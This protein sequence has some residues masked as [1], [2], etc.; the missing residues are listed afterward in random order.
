M[1]KKKGTNRSN[2]GQAAKTG[3]L[4]K[5][6][7]TYIVANAGKIPLADIARN[8]GRRLVSVEKVARAHA[9]QPKAANRS[10]NTVSG[11][12]NDFGSAQHAR[13]IS[14]GL[15]ATELWKRISQE[16][17]PEE[18]RFFEE[19]YQKLMQQFEGNVLP[20]EEMQVFDCIKLEI[21]KSRN[22]IERQKIKMA[23]KAL[24]DERDELLA[25][26][27]SSDL[28]PE[29]QKRLYGLRKEI[30]SKDG[31]DKDKTSEYTMLVQRQESIMKSLKSTRDQRINDVSSGKSTF[32]G[33]IKKLM[34]KDL[35]KV[36]SRDAE[37]HRMA[38][39]KEMRRLAQEHLYADG[40][41]DR[42]IL[43]A[44]TVLGKFDEGTDR[45]VQEEGD[46]CGIGED[47]SGSFLNTNE[48]PEEPSDGD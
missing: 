11:D 39:E 33:L 41:V 21:L 35:Q 12:S 26:R 23:V 1:N 34:A 7:V 19:Q 37:L 8:L 10:D 30:A 6:D 20:S 45:V 24:E 17:S 14:Q 32:H 27:R 40:N 31:T 15:R 4:S 13:A 28:E 18:R 5:D 9:I 29:D 3:R 36:E 38:A 47:I 43:S 44:D 46:A 2:D 25:G 22:L 42:P 48:S 16:F